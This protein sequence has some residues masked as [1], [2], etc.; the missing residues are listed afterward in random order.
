MA[1]E[2]AV[3]LAKCIHKYGARV[4]SLR[5]YERLRYQ[6]TAAV[7]RYSRHYGAIGQWENWFA[8]GLRKSMLSLVP[9]RLAHRIM[10]IV[11]NYDASSAKV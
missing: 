3:I 7:I 1:I 2:D 6:R 11:F 5:N 8:T 4:E 9:E 10:Q